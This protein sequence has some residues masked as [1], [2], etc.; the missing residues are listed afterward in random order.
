MHMDTIEACDNRLK[1]RVNLYSCMIYSN[2]ELI[3]QGRNGF[4]VSEDDGCQRRYWRVR[5]DH[6]GSHFRRTN[7]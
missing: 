3:H 2:G 5:I 6:L 1:I 4:V 7:A